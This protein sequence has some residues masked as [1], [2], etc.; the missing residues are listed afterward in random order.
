MSRISGDG[1][2]FM[3]IK[4][5]KGS[6]NLIMK[7]SCNQECDMCDMAYVEY[8][9]KELIHFLELRDIA[10]DLS[11]SHGVSYLPVSAGV[12]WI[13]GIDE[14]I[15]EIYERLSDEEHIFITELPQEYLDDNECRMEYTEALVTNYGIQY[16][17]HIKHTDVE[18]T[19][20]SVTWDMITQL[21]KNCDP[22]SVQF[23]REEDTHSPAE[24]I[25]PKNNDI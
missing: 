23:I 15:E 3:E 25:K 11:K 17:A 8:T 21:L 6:V 18:V 22:Q 7:A 1:G 10:D 14:D 5:N 16:K 12:N 13:E 9:K 20:W 4:E 2:V 19:T 24:D